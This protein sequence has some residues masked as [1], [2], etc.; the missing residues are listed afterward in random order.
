MIQNRSVLSCLFSFEY[1]TLFKSK[2]YWKHESI[3]KFKSFRL[4]TRNAASST[5]ANNSNFLGKTWPCPNFFTGLKDILCWFFVSHG[6]RYHIRKRAPEMIPINRQM[7]NQ[8]KVTK[9]PNC[10]HSF[11]LVSSWYCSSSSS[12]ICQNE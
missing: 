10:F 5:S 2:H 1:C 6:L 9:R 12:K 8:I 3:G 4:S 7:S 11:V